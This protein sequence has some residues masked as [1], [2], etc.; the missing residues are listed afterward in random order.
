MWRFRDCSQLLIPLNEQWRVVPLRDSK[1]GA[2]HCSVR[3][4]AMRHH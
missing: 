1:Q 4:D 2:R 3:I